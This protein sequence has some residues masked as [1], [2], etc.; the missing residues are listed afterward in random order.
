MKNR[1]SQFDVRKS[2][3]SSRQHAS[4][5]KPNFQDLEPQSALQKAHEKWPCPAPEPPAGEIANGL[6]KGTT[7]EE[8]IDDSQLLR[9][10]EVARLLQVPVSWVYEHTHPRCA[11][12]LPHIKIGKYLR[13]LPADIRNYLEDARSLHGVLR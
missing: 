8:M 4:R 3:A 5:L 9:V 12:P 6:P 2:T 7:G 10:Q 11:T 13:F 1:H